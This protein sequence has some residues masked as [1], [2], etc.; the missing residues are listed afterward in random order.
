MIVIAAYHQADDSQLMGLAAICDLAKGN[1]NRGPQLRPEG[2]RSGPVEDKSTLAVEC[3]L[4]HVHNLQYGQQ[5]VAV[6]VV[7][8]NRGASFMH[9]AWFITA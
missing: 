6:F 8:P 5:A 1:S 4:F 2:S 3:C 7:V 9:F